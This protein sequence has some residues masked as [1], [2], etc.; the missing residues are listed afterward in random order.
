MESIAMN[1]IGNQLT[2]C[3]LL[4]W[5][6][7][8][9]YFWGWE[10][11]DAHDLAIATPAHEEYDVATGMLAEWHEWRMTPLECSR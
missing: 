9:H 5:I 3:E 4:T 6:D 1:C 10:R 2:Q 8:T 7:W 11:C